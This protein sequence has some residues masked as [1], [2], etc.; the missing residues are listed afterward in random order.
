MLQALKREGGIHPALEPI[1]CIRINLQR[2]AR[3]GNLHRVPIGRFDE[4][5]NRIVG[6]SRVSPAH[7]PSNALRASVIADHHLTFGKL[8]GFLVQRRNFLATRGPVHP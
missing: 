8:I 5:V 4:D 3:I 6:A 7:N 2:T 1:A